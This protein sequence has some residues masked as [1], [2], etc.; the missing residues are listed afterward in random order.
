MGEV[1]RELVEKEY[2]LQVTAPQLVEMLQRVKGEEVASYFRQAGLLV[3]PYTD[4]SQSGVIPITYTLKVPVVA[5][6]IGG[7]PEQVEDGK[8]GLLVPPGNVPQLA[9]ACVRLLTDSLLAAK[10][11]HARYE[12]AMREW[13][14]EHIADQVIASLKKACS[15]QHRKKQ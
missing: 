4:A 15:A 9:E 7:I 13:S 8:T 3:V 6:R 1:G 11:G 12:K 2:S 5:T 10:L 14:W